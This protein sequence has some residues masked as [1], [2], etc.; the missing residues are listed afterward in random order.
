MKNLFSDDDNYSYFIL[1][2][3]SA[4]NF[5]IKTPILRAPNFPHL[6]SKEFMT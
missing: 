2:M 6:N 4:R 1:K 5:H 3:K